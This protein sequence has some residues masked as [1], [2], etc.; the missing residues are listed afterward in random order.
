M[1]K[2]ILD[3]ALD[4]MAIIGFCVIIICLTRFCIDKTAN[5]QAETN[6]SE[7]TELPLELANTDETAEKIP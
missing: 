5:S 2:K 7:K 6:N 4:S 3:N 1:V